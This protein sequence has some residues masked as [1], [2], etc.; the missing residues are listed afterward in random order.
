MAGILESGVV[1]VLQWAQNDREG[2]RLPVQKFAI[3]TEGEVIGAPI[4]VYTSTVNAPCLSESS[5]GF[6][7]DV[8]PARQLHCAVLINGDVIDFA[9]I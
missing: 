5:G 4:I 8:G 7:V 2:L 9:P 1:A 6:H 3:F